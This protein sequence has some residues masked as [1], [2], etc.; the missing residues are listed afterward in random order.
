MD[1]PRDEAVATLRRAGLEDLAGRAE[2]ELP[3]PV[4][5]DELAQW[6]ETYGVSRGFLVDR[7]GGSP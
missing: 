1:V 6:A 2:S 3:D 5:L 7:M 4:G